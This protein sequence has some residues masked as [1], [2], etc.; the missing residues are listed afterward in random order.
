MKKNLIESK[1]EV[2]FCHC[3]WAMLK[4]VAYKTNDN[5]LPLADIRKEL[6]NLSMLLLSLSIPHC[7]D[8][9]WMK[10]EEGKVKQYKL[11]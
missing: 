5:R 6:P 11:L 7:F 10:K 3:Y 9:F 1:L 8:E 4:N 2:S